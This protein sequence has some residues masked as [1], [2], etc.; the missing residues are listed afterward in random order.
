MALSNVVCV[1]EKMQREQQAAPLCVRA[2]R[3]NALAVPFIA[4]ANAITF[5]SN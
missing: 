4:E 2:V 3:Y 5:Q 1:N